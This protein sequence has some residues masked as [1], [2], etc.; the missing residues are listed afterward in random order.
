MKIAMISRATLYSSP[1]GDTVQLEKTALE[2]R[3]L[4]VEVDIYLANA[5]IDYAKYDLLHF[6]NL[7]RPADILKHTKN[8]IPY[9]IS[10][11]FVDYSEYEKKE[12][13]GIRKIIA[14]MVSPD[15]LEYIKVIARAILGREKIQSLS[16]LFLGHRW[17]VK[18]ALKNCKAILPNSYSEQRRVE[19]AYKIKKPAYVIPNGVETKKFKNVKP[20]KDYKDSVICVGRIEGCKNQLRLIKAANRLPYKFYLI[21]KHSINDPGYAA[22]CKKTASNNVH[23]IDHLPQDELFSIMKAAK[24]HILPSWIETCGLVSLEAA[25]LDCTIVATK[26]GDQEDYL[27]NDAIY[28]LPDNV[29]S[30]QEAIVKAYES[31]LSQNLKER[32]IKKYTWEEAAKKTLLAY[33]EALK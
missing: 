30:I 15:C 26:K 28:C 1:G 22:L 4:G 14:N 17:A 2:L 3:K 25:Y 27:Q 16:Y 23:F 5:K 11:I 18:K 10:T 9:L 29:D 20:N 24:V 31:E 21:G 19:E 32:I 33:N 7:I 12:T 8:N 13:F 6:F